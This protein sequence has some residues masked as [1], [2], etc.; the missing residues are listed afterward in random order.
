MAFVYLFLTGISKKIYFVWKVI[1]GISNRLAKFFAKSDSFCLPW[2]RR[3]SPIHRL[4]LVFILLAS[5]ENQTKSGLQS[6]QTEAAIHQFTSC[7]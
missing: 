3:G 1:N 2:P 4:P 7:C 5:H 6:F